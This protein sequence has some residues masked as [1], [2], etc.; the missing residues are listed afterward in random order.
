MGYMVLAPGVVPTAA[1]ATNSQCG[2][3]FVVREVDPDALRVWTAPAQAV[4]AAAAPSPHAVAPSGWR[5]RTRAIVGDM[6]TLWGPSAYQGGSPLLLVRPAATTPDAVDSVA[7]ALARAVAQQADSPVCVEG[8]GGAG[9][10]Q[11][12]LSGLVAMSRLVG[13]LEQLRGDGLQEFQALNPSRPD[14]G[15]FRGMHEELQHLRVLSDRRLAADAFLGKAADTCHS[16]SAAAANAMRAAAEAYRNV[17]TLAAHTFE[18]RHGSVAEA[19]AAFAALAAGF[20]RG[21]DDDAW[22]GYWQRADERLASASLRARMLALLRRLVRCEEDARAHLL[23]ATRHLRLIH[24][25]TG[26]HIGLCQAGG[27][28]GARM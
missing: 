14:D 5:G 19:D 21:E 3:F 10:T 28:R 27:W 20:P 9:A 23:D 24:S 2:R 13:D 22:S 17:G 15:Q 26:P 6:D 1:E 12:Y 8:W 7:A 18:L 25:G 16:R 4:R 11:P